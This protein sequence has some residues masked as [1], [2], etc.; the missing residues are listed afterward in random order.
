MQRIGSLQQLLG[1]EFSEYDFTDDRLAEILSLLSQVDCWESLEVALG[2]CLVRVYDLETLVV[3]HD[4]STTF[5]FRTK[6][7]TGGLLRL[8]HSKDR[9][10]D[11]VQLKIMLS[12]LDEL[13]M[14]VASTVW[15]GHCA[16]DPLYLPAVQQVCQVLPGRS[17][18]HVGDC[19]FG[20]LANRSAVVAASQHYLCPLSEVQF[21]AQARKEAIAALQQQPCLLQDIRRTN[22]LGEEYLV[23]KGHQWQRH[24]QATI[25]GQTIKWEER[26]LLVCSLRH[27][28][29]AAEK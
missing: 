9:R 25:N 11:Q 16:D 5:S 6:G 8:G 7:K 4:S 2:N 21:S 10:P 29:A 15:P 24:Q 23:A 22:S 13:G 3:R 17:L 28:Q 18:L 1:S 26:L 14:P 20:S 19:K 12:T 27:A